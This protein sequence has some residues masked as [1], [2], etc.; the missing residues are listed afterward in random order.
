MF[1]SATG[2][3]F[4]F[5]RTA[6]QLTSNRQP[7]QPQ[8]HQQKTFSFGNATSNSTGGAKVFGNTTSSIFGGSNAASSS[9]KTFSFSQALKQVQSKP[10]QFEGN[11][12][13]ATIN[14]STRV[15]GSASIFGGS[16]KINPMPSFFGGSQTT[17]VSSALDNRSIL[18]QSKFF[19]TQQPQA[20][21]FGN[22]QPQQKLSSTSTFGNKIQGQSIFSGVSNQA[23][24]LSGP[25]EIYR[26]L[27][28]LDDEEKKLFQ[29]AEFSNHIPLKPPPIEL[30]F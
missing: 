19:P 21:F 2:S 25:S 6:E 23:T 20:S 15:L 12:N 16:T 9:A 17:T 18:S 1:F 11:A 13:D 10:Q 30:C 26:P 5:N 14:S 4:S 27:E 22:I 8:P 28:K 3:T 29:Q 7:G 24:G